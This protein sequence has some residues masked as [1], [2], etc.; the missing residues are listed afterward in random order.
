MVN[1][2]SGGGVVDYFKWFTG[3]GAGMLN[4]GYAGGNG[5]DSGNAG[6]WRWWC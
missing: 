2:G 6:R 4:Q 5:S 1:G 3:G